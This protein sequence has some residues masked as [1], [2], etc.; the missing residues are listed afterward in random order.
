MLPPYAPKAWQQVGLFVGTNAAIIHTLGM[1]TCGLL[2]SYRCH[3]HPH[4]GRGKD[5]AQGCLFRSYRCCHHSRRICPR[6]LQRTEI[7][8]V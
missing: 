1:A 8:W 4:L 7:K 3:H 5:F 6:H 2:R